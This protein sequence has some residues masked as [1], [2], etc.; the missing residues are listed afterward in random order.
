MRPGAASSRVFPNVIKRDR[1]EDELTLRHAAHNFRIITASHHDID[2]A[3]ANAIR[4]IRAFAI[5]CEKSDK[6][7]VC[8]GLSSV[9]NTDPQ[10]VASVLGELRD[11]DA[12][13]LGRR[14]R[15]VCDL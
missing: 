14:C 11:W 5:A 1:I 12:F 9:I 8:C 7:A 2:N 3:S 4:P 6:A 10:M 13:G 15:I